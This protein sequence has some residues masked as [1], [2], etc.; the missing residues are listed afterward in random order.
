MEP[1]MARS[2]GSS[3]LTDPIPRVPTGTC[4]PTASRPG[5]TAMSVV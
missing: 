2:A 4:A 5:T 1:L 3:V